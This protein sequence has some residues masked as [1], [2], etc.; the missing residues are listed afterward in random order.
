[1][2][3][4][5]V[6]DFKVELYDGSYHDV[7]SNEMSFKMAGILAFRSVQSNCRPVLLEPIL[8]LD[9]STP[10][11]YQGVVMGDLSSRRGHILGTEAP[12]PLGEGQGARPRGRADRYA[13]DA[14]L[15]HAWTRTYR[16]KFH[17]YQEVPPDAR[18]SAKC[19]KKSWRGRR[20]AG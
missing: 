19:G 5:P 17:V 9:V 13:T 11:D 4:Y 3:G 8:E 16:S 6:V 1:V 15:D 12:T 14:A 10:D 20:P 18:R 2:A 7:D